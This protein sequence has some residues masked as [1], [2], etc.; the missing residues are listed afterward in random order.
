MNYKV[1]TGPE[2]EPLSTEQAKNW[3]KVDSSADD[4]LIGTLITAARQACEE[5]L[6]IRLMSQTVEEV[7]DDFPTAHHLYNPY[8]EIRLRLGPVQS[9][10]S[11][12]YYDVNGTQQTW[13]TGNY[14]VNDYGTVAS[15]TPVA[16]GTYPVV[17]DRQAAITIRYV[18]GYSASGDVPDT[19]TTAMRLMIGQWY[20]NREDSVR[21]MPT[22]AEWLL[23]K[24]R[25]YRF[26]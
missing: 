1:I 24:H 25:I 11:V 12:K 15:I 20:D 26:D 7:H 16:D 10:T 17:Q 19:I 14:L 18:V 4:A 5:Y 23:D 3:L 21:R 22:A 9:V 6:G 13:A 8:A 2:A